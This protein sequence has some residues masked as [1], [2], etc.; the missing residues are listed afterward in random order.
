[1]APTRFENIDFANFL[2]LGLLNGAAIMYTSKKRSLNDSL[3]SFN[4]L[5]NTSDVTGFSADPDEK[6]TSNSNSPSKTF[7]TI[8]KLPWPASF[9]MVY[10]CHGGG[11]FSIPYLS[12]IISI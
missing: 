6:M 8:C 7:C 10:N 3:D 5:L 4:S 1:M 12:M 9:D 11:T 2:Y